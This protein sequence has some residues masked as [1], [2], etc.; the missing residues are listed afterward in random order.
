MYIFTVI[1][2]SQNVT[3]YNNSSSCFFSAEFTSEPEA[4]PERPHRQTSDGETE[5]GNGVQR[6]PGVCRW[7]HEYAGTNSLLY[8]YKC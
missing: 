1:K 5:V 6:L 2:Y 7:V 3:V 8:Q 4:I